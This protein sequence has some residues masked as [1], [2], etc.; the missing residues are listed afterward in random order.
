[1]TWF[2]KGRKSL[3]YFNMIFFESKKPPASFGRGPIAR[4][5]ITHEKSLAAP[6]GA[7]LVYFKLKQV[8]FC[9]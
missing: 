7:G 3:D 6:C 9:P 1:M 5:T 4:G 2:G 8:F